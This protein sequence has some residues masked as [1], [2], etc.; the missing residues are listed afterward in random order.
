MDASLFPHEINNVLHD[1][2]MRQKVIAFE[3]VAKRAPQIK[4]RLE[5]RFWPGYYMR[6]LYIPAGIITTGKIHKHECV[7]ILAEGE[8]TTLV[9]DELKHIKAPHIHVSPPGFKRVSYTHKD[10]VWI[11]LH[12][13]EETDI[14]KLEADLVCDTE[15]EYQ[16]FLVTQERMKCLS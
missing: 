5:H 14:A 3:D 4:L 6:V 12:P 2:S 7:S 9:G 11:T 10:S 8:R 16:A 1:L 13:T 15:E